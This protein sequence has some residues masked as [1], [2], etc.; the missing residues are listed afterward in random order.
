M[1]QEGLSVTSTGDTQ[2][3]RE[4]ERDNLLTAERDGLSEKC[5]NKCIGPLLVVVYNHFMQRLGS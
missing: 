5:K 2:K 1:I 4:I 3:A